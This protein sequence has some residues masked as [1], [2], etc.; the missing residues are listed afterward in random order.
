[1]IHNP[2]HRKQFLGVKAKGSS[3]FGEGDTDVAPVTPQ[4]K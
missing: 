4:K 1:M 3:A 2:P